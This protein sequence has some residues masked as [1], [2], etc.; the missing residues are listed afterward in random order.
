RS[1][2]G[3]GP[4]LERGPC[5]LR[6]SRAAATRRLHLRHP[7]ENGDDSCFWCAPSESLHR[8]RSIQESVRESESDQQLSKV[9]ARRGELGLRL[10]ETTNV[11]FPL[12][13][14]HREP[15]PMFGQA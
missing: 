1:A 15:V 7:S 3:T 14:P 2:W 6:A 9:T 13:A 12:H 4:A 11:G 8:G 5:V 10:V